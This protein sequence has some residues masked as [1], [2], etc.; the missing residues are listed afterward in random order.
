MLNLTALIKE[1]E[2]VKFEAAIKKGKLCA[3][4]EKAKEEKI[5]R[6]SLLDKMRVDEIISAA[7]SKKGIPLMIVKS[8]LP[9][10]N[11]EISKILH[12]IVDFS[13]E[14]E[15]DEEADVAE[16]YINYGDSKRVIEL[17]SG[18]E[19]MIASIALRVALTNVSSLAKPDIDRKST[20]LNSSHVSE[21]RMPSSA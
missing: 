7:F 3:A 8:Q 17:C 5:A 20:R 1:H 13:I 21:S 18:M 4:L 14:L 10:I 16:I 11:T 2:E 12:G 19:K 6:D 15:N 9:V